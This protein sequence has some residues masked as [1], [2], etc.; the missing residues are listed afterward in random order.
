MQP[1]IFVCISENVLEFRSQLFDMLSFK[2]LR[3]FLFEGYAKAAALTV[4]KSMEDE[5]QLIHVGRFNTL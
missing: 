1:I 3:S 4:K 5:K 2:I